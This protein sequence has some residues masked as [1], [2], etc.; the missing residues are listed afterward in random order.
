M[1]ASLYLSE[2]KADW[3]AVTAKSLT[4]LLDPRIST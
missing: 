1:E 4:F 3:A 2:P